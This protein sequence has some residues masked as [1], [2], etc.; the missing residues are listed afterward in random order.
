VRKRV[1]V[2]LTHS[3]SHTLSHTHAGLGSTGR[4]LEGWILGSGGE[5]PWVRVIR[6][7]FS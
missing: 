6:F 1:C 7:T 3:L 2:F 4:D 5:V